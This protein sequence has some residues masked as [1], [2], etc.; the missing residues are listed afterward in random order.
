MENNRPLKSLSLPTQCPQCARAGIKSKVIKTKIF[1]STEVKVRCKNGQVTIIIN[2]KHHKLR[3]LLQCPWQFSVQSQSR[4]N[5]GSADQVSSASPEITIPSQPSSS[6][7]KQMRK[8]TLPGSVTFT[9]YGCKKAQFE[10]PITN[11]P[12]VPECTTQPTCVTNSK[13]EQVPDTISDQGKSLSID[14]EVIGSEEPLD[15]TKI[16]VPNCFGQYMRSEKLR[17]IKV[18]PEAKLDYAKALQAWNEMPDEEKS[19][20]RVMAKQERIGLGGNYR[21]GLKRKSANPEDIK[22]ATRERKRKERRDLKLKK[23]DEDYCSVKFKSILSKE[24]TKN[25]KVDMESIELEKEYLDLTSQNEEI[26]QQIREKENYGDSWKSK[27][28]A[29]YEEHKLCKARPAHNL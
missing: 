13:H 6:S 25:K 3:F 24:E 7:S 12:P 19:R 8:E 11:S 17:L 28:K 9:G 22:A 5:T 27:Y 10:N 26:L 16:E 29:L 15:T 14:K 1:N 2:S 4:S 21:K 18:N 23:V 20:F